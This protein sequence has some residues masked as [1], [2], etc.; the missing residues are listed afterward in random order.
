MPKLHS[1]RLRKLLDLIVFGVV[2]VSVLACGAK[3]NVR[4]ASGGPPQDRPRSEVTLTYLGAAGWEVHDGASVLLVDPYF[5]RSDVEDDA[6]LLVPNG[7]AI[8]RHSPPRA[9]AILIGHS[10]YDHLLDAP[11][12]ARN[13]GTTIVG[14]DS[15]L[16]VARAAG[17]PES[18]LI[19]VEGG[20]TLGIGP[21]SVRVL[22]GR[23][24][25]TG[26]SFATIGRG[27]TLPMKAS[28]YAVGP[29]LQYLVR[30]A[31]QRILILFIGSANFIESELA[32]TRP[33]V[34]IIAT[35]L[36]EKIP[37]YSCRLMKALGSP[38]LVL[39]N[40]FDA[41][42]EQLGPKQ[43]DLD[44]EGRRSL[45]RF[46]DEVH[47]CAPATKVVVPEHFTPISI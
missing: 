3:S 16:N 24:S 35:S 45:A 5:T 31:A 22:R 30:I 28:D 1:A 7:E 25:E 46:A 47:S 15:T 33:T 10:H 34:A 26:A 20:E 17:L 11:T 29:T 42:W 44:E 23:H 27:V 41:H 18:S 2:P 36:R 21:F 13:L 32:G 40:H 43:L 38:P 4:T 8:A 9:D 6:A 37:D 14:T 12:I 19:H 39:T